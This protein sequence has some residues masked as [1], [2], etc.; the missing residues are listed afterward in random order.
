MGARKIGLMLGPALAALMLLFGPPEGLNHAAWGTGALMALMAV[1][2]ATEAI[3]IPA[4]SLLPLFVLPLVGAGSPAQTGSDYANHIVILLLGG[5]I[6]ALGIERW[7]LH[8]RIALN[9]ISRVGTSPG[10]IVFGFMLATAVLS[11]WISNTASTLMM[12]PIAISASAVLGSVSKH[13]T[14]ALLLGVCYAASIGGVA[15][16][17]GTPTNLIAISWL[18]TEAGAHIG[19]AQWMAFGLPAMALLLPVAWWNVTRGMPVRSENAEAVSAHVKSQLIGIGKMTV[20]ETRVAIVFGITATLWLLRLPLQLFLEA[21]GIE[22]LANYGGAEV[23]MM[24]AIFGGV[25][26]FLVPAGGGEDRGLLNWQ[27]AEQIPWGV[28]LLFGGGIAMGKAISRTGLSEWIGENLR[29][30][31][32]LPPLIFIVI[33]VALVIFLTEVTS[34]VATMTTLAPVL[35]SLAVALGTAP[36]S[37]LGPAAVAASCAFMLPVATAPNAIVYGTGHITIQQMIRKGF[38]INLAG[39]VIIAAVG[40]WIAPLVL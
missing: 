18:Q 39:I 8:Q 36:E 1:W 4:T 9:V 17:I 31:D 12:V 40:Y 22:L 30:L 16:P 13:F 10:A 2:W 14:T 28:L 3:P 5:F 24:I 37:L 7:N 27:E 32:V 34:N 35:G 19:F 11:M 21:S 6:V 38:Y 33:V 15:T 26:M 25:L 29:V 23:D 20:Q